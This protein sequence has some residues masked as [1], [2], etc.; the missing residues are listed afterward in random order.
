MDLP[1]M[2]TRTP[3]IPRVSSVPKKT[4]K[5]QNTVRES[6][7]Q[8]NKVT[9]WELEDRFWTPYRNNRILFSAISLFKMTPRSTHVSVPKIK[10]SNSEVCNSLS[11]SC[12]F[13]K[14]VRTQ[15]VGLRGPSKYDAQIRGHRNC[16][17]G[18]KL[19]LQDVPV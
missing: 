11:V 12:R 13:G 9:F 3:E 7:V 17:T 19:Y 18:N 10:L 2:S 1:K 16:D 14:C 15:H 4:S 6:Q 8:S 5:I